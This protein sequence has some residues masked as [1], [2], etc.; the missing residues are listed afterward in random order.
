MK[1][2]FIFMWMEKRSLNQQ[3]EAAP[4]TQKSEFNGVK[5]RE[6]S[7]TVD[8]DIICYS[9]NLLAGKAVQRNKT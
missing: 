7:A 2:V 9:V 3:K 6:N 4:H 8:N 5:R 1:C